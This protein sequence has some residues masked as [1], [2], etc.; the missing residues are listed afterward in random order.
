MKLMMQPITL[1][2][3]S[4]PAE[5][6]SVWGC[7]VSFVIGTA[8]SKL[9]KNLVVYIQQMFSFRVSEHKSTVKG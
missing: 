9:Y 5:S 2:L 7:F 4:S 1:L 8:Q 6:R 3:S